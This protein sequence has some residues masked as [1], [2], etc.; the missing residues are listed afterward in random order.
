MCAS[1]SA[2]YQERLAVALHDTAGLRLKCFDAGL[3][4]CNLP[5]M[6]Q[7]PST[8][9][10]MVSHILDVLLCHHSRPLTMYILPSSLKSCQCEKNVAAVYTFKHDRLPQLQS[11]VSQCAASPVSN[12][13]DSL[14]ACMQRDTASCCR[15]E[16]GRRGH[17][18]A[19]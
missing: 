19:V 6:L 10:T 18:T 17:K 16:Q 3:Q 4:C 8:C 11:P 12:Q 5:L 1:L 7:Q 14:T 15:L 13:H 2:S 9:T